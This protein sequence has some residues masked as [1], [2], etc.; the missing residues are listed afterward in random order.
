MFVKRLS[1]GAAAACAR[2]ET[3]ARLAASPEAAG[4][5]IAAAAELA[6]RAGRRRTLEAHERGAPRRRTARK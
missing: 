1:S 4:R 2:L 3:F 6:E 5:I